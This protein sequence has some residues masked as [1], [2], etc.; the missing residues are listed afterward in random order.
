[1]EAK[2]L[3]KVVANTTPQYVKLICSIIKWGLFQGYKADS[4][5]WNHVLFLLE[6]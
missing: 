3:D 1:M 2:L 6:P 4:V 5:F